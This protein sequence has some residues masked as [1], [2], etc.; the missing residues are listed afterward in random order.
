[1]ATGRPISR[2]MLSQ[3]L[4]DCTVS[5]MMQAPGKPLDYGTAVRT[6]PPELW[7]AVAARDRGCRFDCD[8]NLSRCDCHHAEWADNGGPTSIENLVMAC[9][10]HH[11]QIHKGNITIEL[12][13]DGT[14]HITY[15]DGT[16]KTTVPPGLR[17]TLWPPGERTE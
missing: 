6:V 10:W 9:G 3:L 7:A 4:C 14:L 11:T 17:D 12:E 8:Q 2:S 1:M 15:A 13:P 5:R 16:T